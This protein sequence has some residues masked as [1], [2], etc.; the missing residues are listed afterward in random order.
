MIEEERERLIANMSENDT[1]KYDEQV[2]RIRTDYELKIQALQSEV[3]KYQRI[4]L[5]NA[6]MLK[7]NLNTEKE[8]VQL[9]K[10]VLDMK[11]L[12]VKLINQL[13]DEAIRFKREE[14][15]RIREIAT[16][17]REHLKKDSQIKVLESEKKCKEVIL[18]R[19]QEQL[20]ALRRNTTRLSDKASGKNL[21]ASSSVRSVNEVVVKNTVF[22]SDTKN[23]NGPEMTIFKKKGLFSKSFNVK[24]QKLDQIVSIN[25]IG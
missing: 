2:R 16:L 24:W 1:S 21:Q 25:L 9:N 23:S 20:Q 17:K 7:N 15:N 18:K 8:L 10:E 4:K 11:R 12:K 13:K 6:E 3:N 5:K 19:K 14:Q 22:N